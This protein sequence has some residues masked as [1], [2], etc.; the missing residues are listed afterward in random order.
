MASTRA[1]RDIYSEITEKIIAALKAGTVPWRR[2]W[3]AG[4]MPLSMSTGRPYRGVNVFILGMTAQIE[5]H[6]S[7]W[8]GTYN[9]IAERDGQIRKGEKST[10][11]IL[12]RPIEK[13]DAAGKVVERFMVLRSYNVFNEDQAEWAPEARR[14][15]AIVTGDAN[16]I[17]ACDA[18]VA[19]YLVGSGGRLGTGPKVRTGGDEAYYSSRTDHVQMPERRDFLTSE[20]YYSALFHELAHSTG[21]STRL[22]REGIVEGHRFGDEMY[23]K[24]ELIAE[25]GAAMMCGLAG[26]EQVTLENSAAY[27]ASWI[28]VFDE[29]AKVLVQAGAAA[30]RAVDLA[31][32]VV[33]EE[34]KEEV[35]A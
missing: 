34:E 31:T 14:P 12:W 18:L 2:P 24:E 26:I 5:G 19:G 25:M 28:R 10:M 4:S 7:P 3:A 22:N 16:P 15:R 8:W 13:K 30:Q 21:H 9:Q 23:S 29:D 33:F 1:T 17:E 27:I 35:A 20:G 11:I 6:G 32:S